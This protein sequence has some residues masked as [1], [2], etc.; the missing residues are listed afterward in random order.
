[1]GDTVVYGLTAQNAGPD[2]AENV[3][4]TDSLPS[5][6]TYVSNDCGAAF[7][8]PTLTWSIG[9]LAN[10]GSAVCN[11][12][13]M[14]N[15]VGAIDN[16]AT[17]ATTTDDPNPANNSGSVGLAG[18]MLA[19]LSIAIS[20]DAPNNL[21]VGQQYTYTVTG[22]NNGPSPATGVL[23]NL[24]LSGKVSFV[25]SDCGATSAGNV[26]SWSV[27]SLAV[28]ASSTC[29]IVVAVVAAGD[30]IVTASVTSATPDPN[31]VNNSAEL[32]VGFLAV[33]V[34]TLGLF[35]MLLIGLLLAGVGLVVIRR[36]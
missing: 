3:V 33:Q 4:V 10:G 5:N 17:I 29:N 8:A 34:P 36:S 11:V 19:D 14:V 15:A 35:S 2:D 21:G 32:V 27:P 7:T 31:L 6:L 13:T 30:I 16:T 24:L 1:I 18:A 25:S 26:V 22:T 20:S 23:F 9:T 12:S 28:G